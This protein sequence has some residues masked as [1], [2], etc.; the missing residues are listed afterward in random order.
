MRGLG[1]PTMPLRRPGGVE[2]VLVVPP[3]TAPVRVGIVVVVVRQQQQEC[4]KYPGNLELRT[5]YFRP[6]Y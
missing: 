3:L 6:P 5:R 4:G 1:D 2:P